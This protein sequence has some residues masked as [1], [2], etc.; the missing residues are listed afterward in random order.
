MPKSPLEPATVASLLDK[1]DGVLMKRANVWTYPSCPND[2]SGT[3]LVLP[4]EFVSEAAVQEALK[5]G[6][7][8]AKATDTMGVVTS[9]A[10]PAAENAPV[11]VVNMMQAGSV[12]AATELPPN[13]RPTHD[14]G[15]SDRPVDAAKAQTIVEAAKVPVPVRASS[16]GAAPAVA[17]VAVP[18]AAPAA[19]AK[20][21]G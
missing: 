18:A 2:R 19:L 5:S 4:A 16:T 1:G 12:E 14:A 9:V 8:V 17:P 11:R 6:D 10:R 20:T 3:N 13:S 15:R 21:N 7:V